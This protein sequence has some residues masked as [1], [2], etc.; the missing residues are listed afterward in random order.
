MAGDISELAY[1]NAKLSYKTAEVGYLS[2][3]ASLSLLSK[4]YEDTRIMSPIPGFISRKHISPGVMVNPGTCP[5][6][7]SPDYL[8]DHQ[9]LPKS[10]SVIPQN[11]LRPLHR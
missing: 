2:A 1:E 5:C 7:M 4:A 10:S 3:D 11:L 6:D 9:C 8:S